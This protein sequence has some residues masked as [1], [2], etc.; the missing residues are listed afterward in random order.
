MT[1]ITLD[2]QHQSGR[3]K[4]V[5]WLGVGVNV[6]LSLLK[7]VVGWFTG[8]TALL[9]DA[10]HSLSDLL[11]DG[12]TLWA[13]ILGRKPKDENHPYGHGRFETIGTL[14][15]AVLLGVTAFEFAFYAL[16]NLTEAQAAGPGGIYVAL[17]SI[18]LKE[19]LFRVT[20]WVGQQENSRLLQA[21]A[22]HHR[23][24]ALSSVAA[25]VGVVGAYLGYPV[26]D[27]L[28][29]LVV[30]GMIFKTAWELGKQSVEELTDAVTDPDVEAQVQQLM[31][32]VEGVEDFHEV[33]V[34]R[35]GS[36]LLVDLHVEVGGLLTVSAAHQIAERVRLRITQAL[37]AVSEVLVHVDPEPDP[38]S[39]MPEN[40]VQLMRPQQ[41]IEQD[42][43]DVL[44]NVPEILQITHCYC[45]YLHRHLLVHIH[46]ELEEYLSLQQARLIAHNAERLVESIPDIDEA[47]V[48]LE[49][50]TH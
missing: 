49:F 13:L 20:D 32:G 39:Q 11:S 40:E 42:I 35:M 36:Y 44:Q 47:D 24:D 45:H 8:S 10:G 41:E 7:G 5:T 1:S 15:V 16:G 4:A 31:T 9:A 50:A 3:M 19:V 37:P 18:L 27:P 29:G 46:V 17:L 48:H 12:V 22:W 2:Q 14:F 43:R 34:R 38:P 6:L 28:A 23:S 33:R 21:N 25:L 26:L 30:S